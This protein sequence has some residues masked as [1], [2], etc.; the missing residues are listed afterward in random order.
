MNRFHTLPQVH[1]DASGCGVAGMLIQF[2]EN[3]VGHLVY[4]VPRSLLYAEV[5]YHSTKL[6]MLAAVWTIDRFRNYLIGHPFTLVTDC[7][8]VSYFMTSKESR[9]QVSR[10]QELLSEYEFTVVHRAGEKM[11]HVDACSRA[12]VEL[13]LRTEQADDVNVDTRVMFS[14]STETEIS[15]IQKQDESYKLRI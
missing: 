5:N 10:W 13:P 3:N 12:P 1:T 2:D 9:S 8:A 7:Q 11:A 15:G 14:V 4:C 6:E